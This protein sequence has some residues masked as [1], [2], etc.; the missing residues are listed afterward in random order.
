MN[1]VKDVKVH[2]KICQHGDVNEDSDVFS[3]ICSLQFPQN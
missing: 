1:D 3:L 2:H